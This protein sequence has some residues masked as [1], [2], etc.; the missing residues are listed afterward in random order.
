[1]TEKNK[2]IV[3]KLDASF[4]EGKFEDFFSLCTDDVEWNM[5]GDKTVKGK[6]SI[7]EWLSS[8]GE[9]EPPKINNRTLIAEGDSIAAHGEMTM[10]NKEGETS[11]Y[12]YCD[13]YRFENEKI[14]QLISFMIKTEK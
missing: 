8:M 13:I 9:M 5:V 3:K 2:E 14:A 10:K 7:R 12:S 1:M 11:N 4:T 6:D